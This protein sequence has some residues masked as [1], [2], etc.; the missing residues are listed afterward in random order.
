MLRFLSRSSRLLRQ[1]K[2]N[3]DKSRQILTNPDKSKQIQTNPDKS[4]QIQTNPDK[5][6]FVE[7]SQLNQ[8]FLSLKMTKSLD[9]LRN[10]DGKYAKIIYFLVKIEMNCQE[11]TTF[12]GLDELLDL[13]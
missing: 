8:D 4:R 9:P 6:R 1:I 13:N 11:M 5:S 3:P 2:T 7:K 10:L 12:L